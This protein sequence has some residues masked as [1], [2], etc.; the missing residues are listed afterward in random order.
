MNDTE[1]P[2]TPAAPGSSA[3]KDA[4]HAFVASVEHLPLF[5]G[6]AMQLIRSVDREDVTTAELARL[7]STDAAL[8]AH[9]LRI[10]NSTFY[11]L[12][13]R[14]GTV[15]EALA[16]LGIDLVRRTVIASVLQRPLFAYLH[17]TAVVRTFWR[18]G[19]LCAALAR[20]LALQ[21]NLNGEVAYLAGLMHDVGRLTMLMEYP[22]EAD[23]LLRVSSDDDLATAR[24]IERFGFDHA[25]VGAA[26]LE[27]WDLPPPIV[28]AAL[29]HADET[30]P[31]EP[32][33]GSV[34]QAN[35]ISHEMIDDGE[36]PE[37]P[38]P[39]MV[40]IGLSVKARRQILDEIAA[41]ESDQA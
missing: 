19:L 14:I 15:S 28:D 41:L 37:A 22:Q 31:G 38:L 17:D 12:S 27:V 30:E 32:L 29:R 10:V 5:T 34:W 18:H 6:T 7:I 20:H 13:R 8:V 3:Q 36:D 23:V 33:A 9:L 35:L 39:W 25:Q 1:F 16:V 4:L 2:A 21:K 11:G 24:E 40:Q 26:L